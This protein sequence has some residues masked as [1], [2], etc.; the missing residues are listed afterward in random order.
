M[1]EAPVETARHD[2]T[3]TV[4]LGPITSSVSLASIRTAR[5]YS[6]GGQSNNHCKSISGENMYEH[7]AVGDVPFYVVR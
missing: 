4:L 3:L 7:L 5:Y 1:I 6:L 2:V